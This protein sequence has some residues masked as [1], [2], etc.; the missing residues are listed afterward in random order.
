M[1]PH[2]E[3]ANASHV[4]N[5][6]AAL[7]RVWSPKGLAEHVARDW[8]GHATGE[9]AV[10]YWRVRLLTL[11][12]GLVG[13][14]IVAASLIA[15][16]AGYRTTIATVVLPSGR[17]LDGDDHG[18]ARLP[19]LDVVQD[20]RLESAKGRVSSAI[21]T[22][23]EI[24]AVGSGQQQHPGRLGMPGRFGPLD[25]DIRTFGESSLTRLRV[26]VNRS[27]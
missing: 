2:R 1:S 17:D 18:V 19:A 16:F 14:A 12:L 7:V 23:G 6:R 4:R 11:P 10:L 9:A 22:A 3:A 15:W 13:S 27:A 5:V 24:L 25:F 21:R 8:P 20:R 26:W